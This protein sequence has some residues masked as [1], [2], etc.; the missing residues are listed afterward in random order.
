M[1]AP[2]AASFAVVT[3]G[4]PKNEADSDRLEAA[5]AGA[6][7]RVAPPS[8]ADLILV[9]TC[10]F[11]DAAKQ[12]SIDTLLEACEAAHARGA[13]VAAYGC[14]VARHEAELR[15]AMPELDVLS[16]FDVEPIRELLAG[17]RA[18]GGGGAQR[19]RRRP[20]H[21]YLKISD[22]CDRRCAFCAIPLIKGTYEAV[23]PATILGAAEAALGSGARE[24]VLVGQDTSRWRWPGYGGLERLLGDLR[25]RG[26]VVAAPALPAAR[27]AL[28][29]RSRG[30][31]GLRR[32]LRGPAAAARR[33]ARP[34]R[35]GTRR[36]R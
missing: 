29:G 18:G 14:L 9:N 4:C 2:L 22:G 34:A 23:A 1:T 25:A 20:A 30:P 12:E 10:G 28:G 24:L 26:A 35:H 3:L 6:G 19:P 15:A 13:R 7:H 27:R 5:L 16:P 36:R 31:G 8:S 21:A 32:A 33:P 17:L 11:I